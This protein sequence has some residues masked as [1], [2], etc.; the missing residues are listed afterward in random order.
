MASSSQL[1]IGAFMADAPEAR[2]PLMPATSVRNLAQGAMF[3]A[4]ETNQT[5]GAFA[6]QVTLTVL[7][8]CALFML[9]ILGFFFLLTKNV[10]KEVVTTSV[11]RVANT[12]SQQVRAVLPAA[13][14]ESLGGLLATVQAPDTA[15]E[16]AEVEASNE[17]L[18]KKAGL[19][20]GLV[21]VVVI[22]VAAATFMGMKAK[23]F[24]LRD[25]TVDNYPNPVQVCLTA[26]IG[27]AAV[28]V[29]ELVFLYT[30][31]A[32]YQP[33]DANATR[34]DFLTALINGI[35]KLP[36]DP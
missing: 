12:L 3:N 15:Q 34:K 11:Q 5:K 19:V 26:T 35:S 23:R 25:G 16:D 24:K 13:Q 22:I 36:V 7:V 33:L 2:V 20:I 28:A 8:S 17:K 32:R 21:A 18:V 27:F 10:E 4:T 30:V 1:P 29:C 9:F 6:A 31:A 14:V